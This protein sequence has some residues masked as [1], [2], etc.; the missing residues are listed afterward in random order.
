MEATYCKFEEWGQFDRYCKLVL[1]HEAIDYLRELQRL[2]DNEVSLEVLSP[3]QWDKLSMTD[4]YPSDSYI[5]SSHGYELHISD[6]LVAG[7]FGELPQQEQSILILHFV[8]GMTDREISGLVG[9]S[10][11]AVQRH[12]AKSLKELRIKLMALM[13]EGG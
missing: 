12:K 1:Y 6:E 13:P 4:Y 7:A 9:M 5:F 11:S 8:L 10:K 3:A 2:R